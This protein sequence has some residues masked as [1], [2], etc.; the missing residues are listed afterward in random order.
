MLQYSYYIPEKTKQVVVQVAA[1]IASVLLLNSVF[2]VSDEYLANL[3][4]NNEQFVA[5]KPYSWTQQCKTEHNESQRRTKKH[6]VEDMDEYWTHSEGMKYPVDNRVSENY[7]VGA[8]LS[9]TTNASQSKVRPA[10][11]RP[12]FF[13]LGG[14]RAA[15]R[16][17][18]IRL[19]QRV[20]VCVQSYTDRH[21]ADAEPLDAGV[22]WQPDSV[23][24][25]YLLFFFRSRPG[26]TARRGC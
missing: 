22:K 1:Y 18:R 8:A 3:I 23:P 13:D 24:I 26:G 20:C 2:I 17:S 14:P 6:C 10:R 15:G 11:E 25:R 21:P 7:R 9:T 19:Q 16:C 12:L 5:R 4:V